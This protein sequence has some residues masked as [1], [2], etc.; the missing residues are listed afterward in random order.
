M[1]GDNF[2]A[3]G[4]LLLSE[5]VFRDFGRDGKRYI[6]D[7]AGD[8]LV[9][10]GENVVAIGT[11]R[12]PDP[13]G[14]VRVGWWPGR[15]F[16]TRVASRSGRGVAGGVGVAASF[17]IFLVLLRLLILWL[18]SGTVLLAGR[19]VG[20]FVLLEAVFKLLDSFVLDGVLLTKKRV[21]SEKSEISLR[22]DCPTRRT[23]RRGRTTRRSV[24]P[25]KHD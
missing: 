2:V 25:G 12:L 10:I 13:D 6:D 7:D 19:R 14:P 22:K 21:L 8:V 1:F 17:V 3:T 18:L 4:A 24:R 5:L 11:V 9:G 20:V 16:V 23:D 15:P